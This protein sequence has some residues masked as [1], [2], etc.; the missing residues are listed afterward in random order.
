MND[1]KVALVTG[2]GKRIGRAFALELGRLGYDL[3]LHY[4]SSQQGVEEVVQELEKLGRKARIVR[5][6]LREPLAPAAIIAELIDAQGRLDLL[7]N[8]AS[9]FPDADKVTGQ[10][11]FQNETVEEFESALRVNAQAP[12][13]LIKHAAGLLSQSGGSVINILDESVEVP[14]LSRAAHTVSK[15][16]LKSVTTLAAESYAGK[17]S[18]FGLILGR[19]LPGEKCSAQDRARIEW[20]GIVPVLETFREVLSGSYESG[21]IIKVE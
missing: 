16:A 6:D 21:S 7:I 5:K 1:R 8:S 13:F 10:H 17:F 18:V 14:Q 19:V 20:S 12:F 15:N 4:F 3:V 11:D 9:T 2:A